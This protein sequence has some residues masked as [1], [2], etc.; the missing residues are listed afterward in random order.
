MKRIIPPLIAIGLLLG[1]FITLYYIKNPLM[2][3]LSINN[4]V[5]TYEIAITPQEQMK[6]LSGR[7]LLPDNH[8][9][10]FVYN[11]KEQYAF[12]MNQMKFPI[13]IIWID[14]TKVVD[15][16]KNVPTPAPGDQLPT[17]AP[18]RPV[19]RVFEVA[20][21]TADRFGIKEGDEVTYLRK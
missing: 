18:K 17:Y 7:D 21:G 13:D 8:G 20:A 3:K 19:N 10:L 9:M 15:I 12:W 2:P 6:G 16:T 11:R 14:D 1:V 5:F 4:H